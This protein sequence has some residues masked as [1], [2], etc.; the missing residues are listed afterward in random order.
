MFEHLLDAALRQAEAS[1]PAVRAAALL[2]IARVLTKTDQKE[3]ERVLDEGLALLAELPEQDRAAIA[4]Q[5]VCLAACVA[6]GRAFALRATIADPFAADKFLFDMLRHGYAAAAI[7]Y[8]VG[9]SGQGEFPYH[10]AQEAMHYAT[11]DDGRRDILRCV[12]R[13]WHRGG[14][15]AWHATE[16]LLQLFRI[17]WRVL[18]EDVA[19]DEIRQ[20]VRAVR[21]GPDGQLNA[22]FG[23]SR[24]T[25]T[26]SSHRTARLFNLLGSLQQLD[27]DLAQ[28]VIREDAELARAADIYPFGPYTDHGRRVEP[29]SA[30]AL[31]QW[32]KD[33]TGFALGAGF[34]R[35]EDEK[36]SDFRDS[37]DFAR[38]TYARDADPMRRN[39]APVEC[40]PSAE[41]FRTILYAAGRYEGAG[42]ARLLDRIP[43]PALRLFAQIEFAAGIAGLDQIGGI[44]REQL[45]RR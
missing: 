45:P 33:W 1:E 21:T 7:E 25:V 35:I 38:R 6:P 36:K 2:R 24:G 39:A 15:T 13:A 32:K 16:S 30:E 3:A 12:L 18:P 14:D 23:G 40:W 22:T 44:T 8:I 29:P 37:F 19:R 17:N 5:A 34:F 4:P 11:D 10:A 41:D 9:W 27:P 28:A 26:L 42:G 31:E 43:E 20:I